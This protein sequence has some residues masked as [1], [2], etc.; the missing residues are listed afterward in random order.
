MHCACQKLIILNKQKIKNISWIEIALPKKKSIK[1]IF[2][3]NILDLIINS[4]TIPNFD[5]TIWEI[6]IYY[7]LID[8]VKASKII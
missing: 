5:K 1:Y 2:H 4:T 3:F 7:N 6:Y 8:K